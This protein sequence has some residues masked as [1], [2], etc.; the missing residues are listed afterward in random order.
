MAV[1]GHQRGPNKR[2]LARREANGFIPVKEIYD[3]GEGVPQASYQVTYGGE[4]ITTIYS[5]LEAL[6]FIASRGAGWALIALVDGEVRG[7]VAR[8]PGTIQRVV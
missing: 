5:G 1:T 7:E 8:N 3:G 6:R 4:I 2:T